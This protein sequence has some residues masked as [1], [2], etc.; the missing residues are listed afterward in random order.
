MTL[1]IQKLAHGNGFKPQRQLQYHDFYV[2][3]K[4]MCIDY[5]QNHNLFRLICIIIQ[6]CLSFYDNSCLKYYFLEYPF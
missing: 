4:L 5:L 3:I 1:K 2:I 6:I